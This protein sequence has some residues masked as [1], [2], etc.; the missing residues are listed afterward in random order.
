MKRLIAVFILLSML[1]PCFSVRAE[2]TVIY[3]NDFSDPST[4]SDF[5]QYRHAWEIK[6]GALHCTSKVLDKSVTDSFSHILYNAKTPLTDYVAEVDYMNARTTGGIVFRADAARASHI[7]NGFFGYIA[8][9]ASTGDKGAFGHAD[10]NGAWGGNINVGGVA[11]SPGDNIHIKVIVKGNYVN[12]QMTNIATGKV[13]YTYTYSIGSNEAH[14]AWN[15]GTVGFRL[16]GTQGYFD[17]FKISSAEGI[18]VPSDVPAED[19]G[20]GISFKEHTGR[21][22]LEKALPIMPYTFEATMYFPYS[23]SSDYTHIILSNFQRGKSGFIF[24]ITKG[25]MP[26]L[27][28]YDEGDVR[29]R[30]TFSGVNVYNG[31]RT[32]I[33][34]VADK[35]NK[36]IHCYEN[37]ELAQTL[38]MT[39][40]PADYCSEYVNLATD[41]REINLNI[42]SGSLINVACY[43]D[44]RSAAEVKADMT[45]P[46]TDGLILHYDMSEASYGEDIADLSKSGCNAIFEEY[47][48]GESDGEDAYAYSVAVVGD[49]QHNVQYQP[50]T[51]AKLYDWLAENAENKKIAFMLGLGDITNDS[52]DEQWAY[53]VQNIAKLDGVVPYALVRGNHDA[54]AAYKQKL[55]GSEYEKSIGKNYYVDISNSWQVFKAGNVNY[56]VITLDY[57]PTAAELEWAKRVAN[58]HPYHRVIVITHSYLDSRGGL[59]DHG[60]QIWN[61]LVK[62]CPNI[63]IVLSGHVFND[64]IVET[65]NVGDAGNKVVQFMINGQ[66]VDCT[67]IYDDKEAAGLVAMFHFDASG[68]KV[69]IEY[70]STALDKYFMK[71]NQ[72]ET[73]VG[74]KAGDTNYDGRVTVTDVFRIYKAVLDGTVCYNGD[75]SGDTKLDITDVLTAI[76]QMF[77]S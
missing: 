57:S 22:M 68:R 48:L 41:H 71:C 60:A 66:C 50:Q 5:S 54:A 27:M 15:S 38:A 55:R 63:E 45:A 40:D 69:R 59:S 1:V 2:D 14:T 75:V 64:K 4:I 58:N 9:G 8:F 28:L 52:T 47:W 61:K 53:A 74:N 19:Y 10:D 49:T 43:S 67:R 12:I 29:T 76:N 42:F 65:A 17:N 6:N 39:V 20:T 35:A 70:Y 30:Y 51:F 46:D 23:A 26:S 16:S 37:G 77:I 72:Y 7:K 31:K 44:A 36:R 56:L 13:V 24:E 18:E 62:L 33:A 34:I 73:V 11:Y 3:E 21:Y 25:G 32:H